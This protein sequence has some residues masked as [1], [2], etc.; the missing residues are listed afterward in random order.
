MRKGK[1]A[2][3]RSFFVLLMM[4]TQLVYSQS[5]ADSIKG[6]YHK[7]QDAPVASPDTLIIPDTLLADSIVFDTLVIDTLIAD[8]L[9]VDTARKKRGCH[10]SSRVSITPKTRLALT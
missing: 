9:A 1:I 7:E 5:V 2:E 4:M 3:S 6:V 8:S 10:R